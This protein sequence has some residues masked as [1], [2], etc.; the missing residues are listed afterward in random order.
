MLNTCDGPNTFSGTI[1]SICG[2]NPGS[3]AVAGFKESSSAFRPCRHCMATKDE[4]KLKVELLCKVICVH[5]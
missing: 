2:D 5:M 3:S 1:V 4:M